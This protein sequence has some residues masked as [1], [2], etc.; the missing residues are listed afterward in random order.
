MI[1][2]RMYYRYEVDELGSGPTA[3]RSHPKAMLLAELLSMMR[4]WPELGP[5]MSA[6]VRDA[7]HYGRGGHRHGPRPHVGV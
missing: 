2:G 3:S 1:E 5:L 7:E 6:C 4:Y